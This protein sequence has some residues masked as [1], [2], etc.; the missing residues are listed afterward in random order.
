[1][2]P[3]VRHLIQQFI[4]IVCYSKNCSDKPIRMGVEPLPFTF[5]GDEAFDLSTQMQRP[6]GGKNM[7]REKK[8]YNYH[9]SRERHCIQC[10]FG[11][12]TNK[13]CIFRKALN[14]N[15]HDAATLVTACCA[16]HNFVRERDGVDFDC[17]LS[18]IG[19]EEGDA[20]IQPANMPYALTIREKFAQY[21]SSEEGSLPWQHRMQY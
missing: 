21:F 6:Y 7:S 15:V 14:I 13:W 3:M 10:S 19:L 9:F 1:M 16:L 12:L 20:L 2:V 5:V 4:K 18:I 17:T 11:I 8:T